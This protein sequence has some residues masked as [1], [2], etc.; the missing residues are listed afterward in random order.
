MTPSSR[1]AKPHVDTILVIEQRLYFNR[2]AVEHHI[3][4]FE[5]CPLR[6]RS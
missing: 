1:L 4:L 2:F 5:K 6:S 3:H